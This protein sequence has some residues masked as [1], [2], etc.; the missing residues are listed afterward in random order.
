MQSNKNDS[1]IIYLGK[2]KDYSFISFNNDNTIIGHINKYIII[3]N[4]KHIFD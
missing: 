1:E 3:I 4:G 2:L